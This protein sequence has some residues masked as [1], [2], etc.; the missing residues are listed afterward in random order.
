MVEMDGEVSPGEF[1]PIVIP[2]KIQ[3]LG[4]GAFPAAKPVTFEQ[5][6]S[7]QEDSQFVEVRGIVRAV[8][9]DTESGY[10][11][12]EI[13]TGGG[14]LTAYASKLPVAQSG[15]PGGSHGDRSR[16]LRHALQSPAT[17]V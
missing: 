5:L 2:S 12:L 17:V 15:E 16:G 7:G 6:A 14:R 10:F 8:R 1:A 13:A 3:I 9:F 11:L 4:T